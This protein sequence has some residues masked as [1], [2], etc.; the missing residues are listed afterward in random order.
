MKEREEY[1]VNLRKR[2]KNKIITKKRNRGTS[3]ER[4]PPTNSQNEELVSLR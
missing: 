4:V 3:A 1:S 2:R